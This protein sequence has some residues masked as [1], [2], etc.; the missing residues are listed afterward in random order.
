METSLLVPVYKGKGDPWFV[1]RT[2][3]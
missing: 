1:D 3:G 2:E